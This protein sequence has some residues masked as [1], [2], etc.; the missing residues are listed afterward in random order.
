MK[1]ILSVDDDPLVLQC[2]QTVL[3]DK[4]YEVVITT[5]PDEC[6]AS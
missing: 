2:F 5:D 4:G 3:K 6:R 1:K